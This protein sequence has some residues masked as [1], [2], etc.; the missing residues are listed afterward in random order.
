MIKMIRK[1][2]TNDRLFSQTFLFRCVHFGKA[3]NK[4]LI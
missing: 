3:M 1:R 2:K 4:E